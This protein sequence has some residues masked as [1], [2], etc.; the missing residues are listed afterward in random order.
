MQIETQEGIQADAKKVGDSEEL[1][2]AKSQVKGRKKAVKSS[3][4]FHNVTNKSNKVKS[5]RSK[6]T[7]NKTDGQNIVK[8]DHV[9]KSMNEMLPPSAEEQTKQESEATTKRPTKSGKA[10]R[11]PQKKVEEHKLSLQDSLR[12]VRARKKPP[13]ATQTAAS[14][15]KNQSKAKTGDAQ[16]TSQ[17]AAPSRSR[18][19]VVVAAGDAVEEAQNA[20]LRR[21]RRIASKR[22]ILQRAEQLHRRGFARV[23]FSCRLYWHPHLLDFLDEQQGKVMDVLGCVTLSIVHFISTSLFCLQNIVNHSNF[24]AL[25]Y[26]VSLLNI[27]TLTL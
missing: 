24:A 23:H 6:C 14:Q 18:K 2:T 17:Q 12:T 21:S 7:D 13:G 20:G 16:F 3:E 1:Q 19:R 4:K 22:W 11:G 9:N 27:S 5:I 25:C 8:D 10:P 15:P 26:F